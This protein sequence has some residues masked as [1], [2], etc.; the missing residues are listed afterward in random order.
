VHFTSFDAAYIESLAAGEPDVVEHFNRYF[1]QLIS[2]KLRARQY[3]PQSIEDIKQETFLR[4]FQTLRREGLRQP[5]RMGAFVNTV[6]N[7]VAMEYLRAG[8]RITYLDEAPET[9]DD[10]VNS[11][12]KLIDQERRE[13]VRRLLD[14][15]PDKNRRLLRAVFL[16][17]RPP[18]EVCAEMGV[19]RNYLRV[20]L[21]RA[22]TQLK[23]ALKKSGRA[24][25]PGARG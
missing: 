19:D 20:L 15:M 24:R 22:R 1:G 17:E 13:T 4:V 7:H 8:S 10:H 14:Q 2:I 12:Q 5:D 21:F 25:G 9:A 16:E 23:E 11:E 3:S 18:D 6:C